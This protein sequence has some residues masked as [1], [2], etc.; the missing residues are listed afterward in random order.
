[1]EGSAVL[2]PVSAFEKDILKDIVLKVLAF[3]C[4]VFLEEVVVSGR[5][6][7]EDCLVDVLKAR[8]EI[9]D[10]VGS[11]IIDTESKNWKIYLHS[12]KL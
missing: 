12:E 10:E 3:S 8:S 4:D 1:M 2:L 6:S 5:S 9:V 11:F 7:G